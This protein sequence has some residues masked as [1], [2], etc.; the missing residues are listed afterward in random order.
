LFVLSS[1]FSSLAGA[2]EIFR[3]VAKNGIPLY[4]NF[5]CQ[6]DSLSQMGGV[7]VAKRASEN[8]ATPAAVQS[9][10]LIAA[11]PP[12]PHTGATEPAPGMTSD[13][14]WTLLGQPMEVVSNHATGQGS[15]E[16][17]QYAD[18]RVQFDDNNVVVAI[19]R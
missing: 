9:A 16:I 1:C 7:D 2:G 19:Q 15:A 8:K 3:C 13:E 6:F 12:Q 5:P 11:T 14:I 18:K 17:W 4:Q 10:T